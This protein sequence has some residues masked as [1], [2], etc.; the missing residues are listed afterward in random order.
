MAGEIEMV[1]SVLRIAFEV[2]MAI[3]RA[4]RAGDTSTLEALR[5]VLVSPEALAELDRALVASQRVKAIAELGS[6]R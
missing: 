4:I 1:G 3:D 2:G 5:P 6:Q